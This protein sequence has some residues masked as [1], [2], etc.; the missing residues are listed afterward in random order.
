[1][2]F[3]SDNEGLCSLL[4][5]IN[6]A[7]DKTVNYAGVSNTLSDKLMTDGL[8]DSEDPLNSAECAPLRKGGGAYLSVELGEDIPVR[9]V[10]I[11]GKG[12]N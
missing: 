5:D 1:M 3:F 9:I 11:L 12:G 2:Y 4:K 10:G 6:V 8:I 7:F